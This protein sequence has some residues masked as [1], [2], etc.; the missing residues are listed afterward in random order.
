MDRVG[1][2]S[3]KELQGPV[4]AVF[5]GLLFSAAACTEAPGA[6]ST[7]AGSGGSVAAASSTSGGS[8]SS[9]GTTGGT[10]T[11]RQPLS[12]VGSIPGDSFVPMS[13]ISAETPDAG[14]HAL[15]VVISDR[16]DACA[17]LSSDAGVPSRTLS[18]TVG[19]EAPNGAFGP[20]TATGAYTVDGGCSAWL[21]TGGSIQL[22]SLSPVE[23]TFNVTLVQATGE[24]PT[25]TQLSGSFTATA[26]PSLDFSLLNC[27]E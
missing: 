8:G 5:I 21:C 23:G 3:V 13:A 19:V 25:E 27:A 2:R 20:P 7:S 15:G 14:G 18:M 16:G 17:T 22:T 1:H 11:G 26:C 6:T 4:K 10:T 9:S 24:E 12:V